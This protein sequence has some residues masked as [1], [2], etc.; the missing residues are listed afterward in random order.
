MR[1]VFRFLGV[2]GLLLLAALPVAAAQELHGMLPAAP[3]SY[4]GCVAVVV[5]QPQ[6]TSVPC[7]PEATVYPVVI[8]R[9]QGPAFLTGLVVHAAAAV[10]Q[11]SRWDIHL[12]GACDHGESTHDHVHVHLIRR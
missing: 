7:H 4:D 1:Q 3:F 5:G 9:P 11:G 8:L 10:P 2:L 12:M 6:A